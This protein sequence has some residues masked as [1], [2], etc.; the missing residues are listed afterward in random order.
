V[1]PW[2][3]AFLDAL[4]VTGAVSAEAPVEALRVEPALITARVDGRAVTISAPPIPAGIWAA[5]GAAV[6]TDRQSLE[7]AQ[8]LDHTWEAPLVP[9][10]LVR[11]GRDEDVAAVARVVAAGIEREP[12]TLLRFRGYAAAGTGETDAWRGGELPRLPPPARRP[13]ESVPKRFGASGT[14]VGGEDLVEVLTRA[15]AAFARE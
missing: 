15:Y 9:R 13:P 12:S 4:G 11:A 5:V 2:A 14:V 3:Q 1:G 10:E 8:V 7:L 6:T